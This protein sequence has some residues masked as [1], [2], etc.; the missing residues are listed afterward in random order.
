M[1]MMIVQACGLPMMWFMLSCEL[2]SYLCRAKRKNRTQSEEE[3]EKEEEEEED[4][5]ED[6]EEE[7]TDGNDEKGEDDEADDCRYD[8]IAG[9][10]VD[11]SRWHVDLATLRGHWNL[12]SASCMLESL[13][14]LRWDYSG[15]GEWP[16]DDLDD[17]RAVLFGAGA[18]STPSAS[19][20]FRHAIVARIHRPTPYFFI[21][22]VLAFAMLYDDLDE[23]PLPP[24]ANHIP[25]FIDGRQA[26]YSEVLGMQAGLFLAGIDH[27]QHA[28]RTVLGLYESQVVSDTCWREGV[29]KVLRVHL[30][31][32]LVCCVDDYIGGN[33][34]PMRPWI[35]TLPF[36]KPYVLDP[37]T[38]P[39]QR[40][41]VSL[42]RHFIERSMLGLD[43]EAGTVQ[44]FLPPILRR[45]CSLT[46]A[47]SN[48][49]QQ[50]EF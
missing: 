26:S 46:L 13:E 45:F 12:E 5:E 22:D 25:V 43:F 20:V 42:L 33:V 49:E 40:F 38:W 31:R 23:I 21:E 24:P 2:W 9:W 17:W 35:D 30:I 1:M 44:I 41:S 11:T 16:T 27:G 28:A 10:H 4:Q 47:G 15:A 36:F 19:Q 32:A 6:Q 18:R 48:Y 3:E 29:A 37:R 8:I 14:R 34:D 39:A 50:K 7:E